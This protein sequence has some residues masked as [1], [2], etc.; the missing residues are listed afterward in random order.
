VFELAQSDVPSVVSV[1]TRLKTGAL[2]QLAASLGAVA[3]G[4]PRHVVTALGSFGQRLG[5]AL[6]MLDDLGGIISEARCHKGHE[7]A[8]TGR[9]TW[10]F[11]WAAR[12]LDPLAYAQLQ[13]RAREVHQRELHPEVLARSLREVVEEPGKRAISEHLS[14]TVAELEA[15][16]GHVPALVEVKAEI[17]LIARSYG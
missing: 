9:A 7:D 1:S 15:T 12:E 10:P 6:Q 5:V 11:A 4:G 8:I 3:A 16:F 13:R 14:R 2:M 17:E